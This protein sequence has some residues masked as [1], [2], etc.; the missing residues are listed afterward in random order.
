M[1]SGP[2]SHG[3]YREA[4]VISGVTLI[5]WA[6]NFGVGAVLLVLLAVRKSY[7]LFPA[8]STY[9]VL[10]LALGILALLVYHR[11]GFSSKLSWRIAW[12]MQGA[13]ICARALAVAEVCRHVLGRYRGIWALAWRIL[14]LCA[15]LVL[16]CSLAA[17][18]VSGLAILAGDRALELAIASVVVGILLFARYYC[19]Q[20]RPVERALALGFCLFS[21][22]NVLNNVIL[23]HYFRRYVEFWNPLGMFVFLVASLVWTWALRKRQA[24]VPKQVL[25]P[26]GVY[27]TMMPEVNLQLRSLNDQ[28]SEFFK[29]SGM[30]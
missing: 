1:G 30:W 9:T 18:H 15:V 17:G 13:V 23:E 16:F 28:L 4:Q 26:L 11:W 20:V 29:P 2:I 27:N 19:V 12:A 25:L 7:R 8:F 5:L 21:C 22:F 6:I 10:N 3:W 14:L 24:G